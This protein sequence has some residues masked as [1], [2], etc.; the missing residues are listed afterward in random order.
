MPLDPRLLPI[1]IDQLPDGSEWSISCQTSNLDTYLRFMFQAYANDG[2]VRT[3]MEDC[4][5]LRPSELARSNAEMVE[6]WVQ[7]ASIWGRPVASPDE[8]RAIMGINDRTE[9][10]LSST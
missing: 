10:S 8:A 6:Q 4:V 2:H 7:T 3:G 9:I 1:L 5:Y